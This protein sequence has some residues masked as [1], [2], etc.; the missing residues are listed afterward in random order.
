MKM[1][2]TLPLSKRGKD[3]SYIQKDNLFKIKW[4]TLE[5]DLGI[6]QIEDILKNYMIDSENWYLLG[7][8]EDRPIAGGLGEY[9]QS[10]HNLS[11]RYVSAVAAIMANENY[12]EYRGKRPIELKRISKK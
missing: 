2:I 10:N 8:S 4:G 7:A 1:K 3:I 12:I 11:S 5:F 9:L 6:A